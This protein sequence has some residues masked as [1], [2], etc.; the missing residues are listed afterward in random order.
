MCLRLADIR[1][2]LSVLAAS[3]D[4]ARLTPADLRAALGDAG[5]IEKA[6][7][8]MAALA[9]ARMAAVGP[10][11]TARRQAARELAHASGTSLA[12]ADKA[13]GA[14]EAMVSQPAV[15]GAARAGELSRV[16]LALVSEAAVANPHAVV[17]LLDL[18]RNGS[19]GELAEGA[20]RARAEILDPSKRREVV[21]AARSLRQHTDA[22]G[23]WWLHAHGTPEDGATVMA[24][25]RPYADKAFAAARAAGRREAPEAYAF[26]G[27]AALAT[28]GGASAPRGEVVVRLDHSALIRGYA[29]NGEACEIAGFG[30]VSPQ[31]VLD[32]MDTGDPFLKAVVTKGHDVAGVTHLGR[33]PNA[34]QQT[35]LDWLFPSCAAEGCG[36]RAAFLQTDHREGWA[37][38]HVTVLGLLDR[39]CRFHH[40]L[41][42]YQGWALVEGR[43]KRALVPPADPRHP[44]HG[45]RP[46]DEASGGAT[47][48]NETRGGD[49]GRQAGDAGGNTPRRR[50]EEVAPSGG[51]GKRGP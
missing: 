35:A 4:P 28:G 9:A 22:G 27:L 49:G 2:A 13:L 15:A 42:T 51:A 11:A 14:A 25:I 6:A 5:A 26:D 17:G 10:R 23:T 18:A 39:L 1:A 41:K 12:E 19:L 30:P 36:T 38:T 3:F 40:D 31:F 21:H 46:H 8:A 16:Q 44:R 24:A 45:R 43:G 20:A 48:P 47:T 7:S 29:A 33:R 50:A 32:M 34:H 37:A